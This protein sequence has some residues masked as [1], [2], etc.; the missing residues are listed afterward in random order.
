MTNYAAYLLFAALV[1]LAPGPDFAVTLRN[2]VAGGRRAGLATGFGVTT[3]NLVQ[4]TA[5]AFGLG[6]MILASQPVFQTIRWAG[7]AY[8]A[9]LGIRALVSAWRGDYPATR[10]RRSGGFRQ[11]FLSN[12]TNPKVL[13]L[14]LSVLPQFLSPGHTTTWDAL[15]LAYTHAGLSFVWLAVVVSIANRMRTFIARRP[16][17]RALDAITGSAML[18]FSVRL[19]TE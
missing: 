18:G 4:G 6:A 12:I 3:S 19:A 5:A 16:V 7:I 1:V 13:A 11:G 10:A 8:L 15:A 14:Y 17:R 2:A 9:Y